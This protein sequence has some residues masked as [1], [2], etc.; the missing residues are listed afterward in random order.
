MSDSNGTI[1]EK[2]AAMNTAQLN[3]LDIQDFPPGQRRFI[4]EGRVRRKRAEAGIIYTDRTPEAANDSKIPSG[5]RRSRV[6]R[7]KKSSNI[8]GTPL[9]EGI[10][11]KPWYLFENYHE[12]VSEK[13]ENVAFVS[14][15]EDGNRKA[16]TNLVGKCK[17]IAPECGAAWSTG[18]IATVIREYRR[19]DG[20][21][22]YSAQ[23]F[24]QRCK[25]CKQMGY[26]RLDVDVYVE[27]VVRRLQ[28]WKGEFKPTK[29]NR[30]KMLPH[31][32]ELCEGCKDGH[33]LKGVIERYQSGLKLTDDPE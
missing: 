6:K 13:V 29:W 32:E 8:S 9:G 11:P 2:L 33:C 15:I 3:G 28:I 21:L 14:T 24:N 31:D 4:N 19:D 25:G 17:C 22:G 10:E 26:M 18:T 7:S 30:R 23:V 12:K 1:R 5:P 16:E 20:K 27:R